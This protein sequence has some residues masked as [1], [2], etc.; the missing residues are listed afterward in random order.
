MG[1]ETLSLGEGEGRLDLGEGGQPGF[2][3]NCRL[4]LCKGKPALGEGRRLDLSETALGEGGRG[5]PLCRL[6]LGEE[7]YEGDLG[8]GGRPL[9]R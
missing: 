4:G 5:G 8:E 3:G 6:Y 1:K 9:L 2:F 7:R